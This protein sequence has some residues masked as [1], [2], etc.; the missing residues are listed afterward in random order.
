MLHGERFDRPTYAVLA[1]TLDGGSSGE[2]VLTHHE[3]FGVDV[4]QKTISLLDIPDGVARSE[5]R[6]LQ[7]LEHDHL[8]RVREAQWDPFA[9]RPSTWSVVP[10]SRAAMRRRRLKTCSRLRPSMRRSKFDSVSPERLVRRC[11]S[12][13]ATSGSPHARDAPAPTKRQTCRDRDANFSLSPLTNRSTPCPDTSRG[14]DTNGAL[15]GNG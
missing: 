13:L 4:V 7:E 12:S 1:S 11:S 5:P 14:Y 15:C 8:I 10:L 3:I 2:I 9:D 6:I